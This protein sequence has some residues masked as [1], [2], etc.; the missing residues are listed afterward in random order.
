MKSGIIMK[1]FAA[2]FKIILAVVVFMCSSSAF[3]KKR[4][5][6]NGGY[7][8]ITD[9]VKTDGKTDVADAIQKVI[10][11][12]PNRTIFFPDGVYL[13]SHSIMTP[14]DPEKSVSLVLANF[15]HLKAAD[16][17][18]DGEAVVRLGAINPANNIKIPGSNYGFT[19]GIIDGSGVAN[20]IS[21]DGGRETKIQNVSIKNTRIGVHIKYGA[22]SGSSDSDISDV[23]IVGNNNSD[24]IGVLVE[25]Y[26]NT[27]LNM[28]I[29]SVNIGVLIKSGGNILRNIH[30]L[31][32]FGDKQNY[33]T[34]CGFV[35]Q[36]GNNW[37]NY[38]YSDQMG[39][40]FRL[41]KGCRA[42]LTDCFCFWYS[43]K[44]PFQTV[45][46]CDGPL[47]AMVKG[48]NVG[49]NGNGKNFT[50]LKAEEGGDG[51]LS[52]LMLQDL[53]LAPTDASALYIK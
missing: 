9:Y 41:A 38:C 22:N 33:E 11:A 45:I 49:F 47:R 29:A 18:S 17:W 52:F 14:A 23:N 3:A 24:A 13:L 28:R 6:D 37:L 1:R 42:Q 20:G 21:I 40:G 32:V 48:L 43:G 46:E 53:P 25:G 2:A 12:N 7:L 10:E 4:S 15:A 36:Q 50:L 44:V 51:I 19:G 31:Y 27:F 8:V 34:S 26:D 5:K 16:T 30:P 39:T 35:V